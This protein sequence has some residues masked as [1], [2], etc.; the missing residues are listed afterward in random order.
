MQNILN[1]VNDLSPTN[2]TVGNVNFQVSENENRTLIQWIYTENGVIMNYKRV[3]LAF[4][5]NA[6]ESII[7]NW[8]IY[9]VSGPSVINAEQAYK[10]ALE[11][12]QNYEFRVGH[13]DGTVTIATIPDLSNAFYQTFF[14][15][16]PYRHGTLIDRLQ[17]RTLSPPTRDPLTLYPSWAFYFYFPGEKI[18][19]CEGIQVGIWGDTGEIR[20][21]SEFGY[22]GTS[23]PTNE[24]DT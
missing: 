16:A 1:S 6:F 13:E 22:Y 19:G 2:V 5:N 18:A 17:N 21:C 15:M 9:S 8:R 10:I 12:A 7:D 23:D 3:A 24:E 20:D 14:G 11:A 4:R